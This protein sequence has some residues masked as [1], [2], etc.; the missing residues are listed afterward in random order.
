MAFYTFPRTGVAPAD[1]IWLV[2]QVKERNTNLRATG[3]KRLNWWTCC[4]K[5]DFSYDFLLE[6]R[7]IIQPSDDVVE[8]RKYPF[9]RLAFQNAV[10]SIFIELQSLVL[11]RGLLVQKLTDWR[12]GHL[13]RCP[14]EDQ[15]WRWYL[16]WTEK[17]EIEY[18]SP[19]SQRRNQQYFVSGNRLCVVASRGQWWLGEVLQQSWVAF[20]HRS[21]WRCIRPERNV[22]TQKREA[23]TQLEQAEEHLM[24]D[25]EERNKPFFFSWVL[26]EPARKD[27]LPGRASLLAWFSTW[28]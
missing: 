1:V 27:L 12:I 26:S 3:N 24:L 14:M 6:C 5:E 21:K 8:N 16:R 17:E 25:T 20:Y 2:L 9:V 22:T 28:D 15:Q 19:T 7:P 23:T 13:V 10:I 4:W 11:A 18:L